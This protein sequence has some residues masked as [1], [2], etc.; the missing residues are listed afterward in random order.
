MKARMLCLLVLMI[1][2]SAPIERPPVVSF[3]KA[4]WL[5]LRQRKKR[6]LAMVQ[7]PLA[8]HSTFISFGPKAGLMKGG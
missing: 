1:S 5:N 7:S 4:D 2:T 3:Y 8:T 6:A